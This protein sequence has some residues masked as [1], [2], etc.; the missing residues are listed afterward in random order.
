MT[1]TNRP[2]R[3]LATA[4]AAALVAGAL[5]AVP[6]AAA[7]PW[8]APRAERII[9]GPSRPGIAAWGVAYNAFTHELVVGDYVSKQVRRYELDG[10]WIAD[11]SNPLGYIPGVV[12]AVAVDPSDGA[13]YVAVTGDGS[14]SR[15]VRKYDEDGN[16]LYGADLIGNITWLAVDD[17]GDLWTPGAFSGPGIHEYSFNDAAETATE[18]RSIGTKGS[19]PGELNR[20][21]GIETDGDGNVYVSDPGNGNVH[22]FGPDGDWRFDVGHKALFPGDIRGVV[23]NDANER[24][25]V[26]NSQVG[27][28]EIFD[29]DGNHL[30]SF[31]ALGSGDG[32]FL[33]G[34]RQLAV[35]PDDHV[36]AAD[37]ASGRVQEFSADGTFLGQF[38]DPPQSPD[39]AGLASARG[40]AVDPVTGDVLIADNW[41]Q[42]VQ[43]FAPDGTLLQVF[44]ERGS[45]PPAGMNYPRS[46]A[47]DPDTRNVWVGNYEGDPDVMVFT[48]GFAVVRHI[49]TPRFV[50]DIE[51]VDGEAFVLFRRITSAQGGIR[52]YDTT[53]GELLR[54]YNTR[55]GWL[56]GIA[57]DPGTG[58]I[59]VTSDSSKNVYIL[60]SDGALRHTVTVDS[61]PWGAT[62]VGDVV[63]VTD[64][65]AHKVIAFDRTDFDRLGTFGAQGRKPGQI[66]G[67]SGIDHNAAGD[68]YVVEDDGA[69]V[70]RFGWGS[71]PN[72]ET[73]KPTIAWT[74]PPASLPLRIQGTASDGNKVMM[75]DVL[76]QD[77]ATGR[78]W[79]A[80][81]TVWGTALIWNRAVVWGAL[82]S[83]SWRFT[84]VPT[85]A[86]TTYTVKARAID[87][88]GNVSKALTGSFTRG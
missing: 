30:D 5:L 24:L 48:P 14:N 69:R 7:A 81:T 65:R 12:S 67:P 68:L 56:R 88:F 83:P 27:R 1:G 57:V 45:F 61:R 53:T 6:A 72:P 23:V 34:A 62:I 76:V 31:G 11:F 47:V 38:P 79:N 13:T 46:V 66:I 32:Q 35:T 78:Y 25:Y 63:Y 43:R 21:T 85:V 77:P 80:R 50:N 33:D 73:V 37:Y 49:V 70:Q 36:W 51:I 58:N 41:N 40:I 20:L 17:E 60:D 87:T 64:T 4:L 2:S 44:G 3:P 82:G 75:V 8:T 59:W 86:G 26:A 71:V 10:T 74:T 55:V 52:V 39:P 9:G 18:L 19:D 54:T 28:I 29:L 42:R 16:Y 22:V 15:D 84:L